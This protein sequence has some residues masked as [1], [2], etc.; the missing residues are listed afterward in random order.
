MLEVKKDDREVC[1]LM[2]EG[3]SHDYK[4]LRETLVVFCPNDPSF[5]ETKARERYL[6]LQTQGGPKK[7]S[8]VALV[9]R[10]ERKSTK[11]QNHKSKSNSESDSS[12]KKMCC[13][14]ETL[15]RRDRSGKWSEHGRRARVIYNLETLET[16]GPKTGF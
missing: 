7:H 15:V 14:I 1:N 9:S 10:A 5:I 2:L 12:K 4:T 16:K 6:D 13:I 3:L 8:S 11:K